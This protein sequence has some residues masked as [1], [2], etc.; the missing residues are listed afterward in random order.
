MATSYYISRGEQRLG[1][2]TKENLLLSHLTKRL[3]DTDTWYREDTKTWEPLGPLV[4]SLKMPPPPKVSTP[5]K[6]SRPL[7]VKAIV[8]IG[9]LGFWMVIIAIFYD[10]KF[11][12]DFNDWNDQ[13]QA[14]SK[15]ILSE[16]E[17]KQ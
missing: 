10:S 7:N 3:H 2:Y 5:N 4:V 1:L 14:H 9:V 16:R 12:H 6:L 11:V 13:L 8:L 15:Q 17:N